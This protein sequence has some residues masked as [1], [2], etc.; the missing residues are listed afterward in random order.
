MANFDNNNNLSPEFNASFLFLLDVALTFKRM[1]EAR[2]NND[3]E[4]LVRA[5]ESGCIILTGY[6]KDQKIEDSAYIDLIALKRDFS[7]IMKEYEDSEELIVSEDFWRC[8]FRLEANLRRVW[9]ISGLQMALKDIDN[10]L[11]D[12]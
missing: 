7:K 12:Y 11:E 4:G 1:T 6:F 2:Q 9:K 10:E 8:A 3:V 5:I